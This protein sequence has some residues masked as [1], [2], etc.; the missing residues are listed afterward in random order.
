MMFFQHL[1][2]LRLHAGPFHSLRTMKW[3]A[4]NLL[5]K[6][7]RTPDDIDRA[8]SSLRYAIDEHNKNR[9]EDEFE[10]YVERLYTR[11][12]WELKYLEGADEE[13][14][15][16]RTEI[17]NLLENWP[18]WADD[19]PS[20]RHAEHFDDLESLQDLWV[21]NRP[22][23]FDRVLEFV[24][25]NEHES[26]A[27]LAL[28]KL[29]TAAEILHLPDHRAR[30]GSFSYPVSA[31]LPTH[32][33]AWAGNVLVETMEIICYAERNLAETHRAAWRAESESR[34]EQAQQEQEERDREAESEKA[35]VLANLR[36]AEDAEKRKA[37]KSLIRH[38]WD[39]WNNDRSRY[40]NQGEFARDMEEK[41]EVEIGRT[42]KLKLIYSAS[43]IEVKL[44]PQMRST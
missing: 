1:Y 12:G 37:A 39:L 23:S 17:R 31:P 24:D 16:T 32:A 18:D 36:W 22:Y 4:E 5:E 42:E 34:K 41:V 6:Q 38:Y 14:G 11:G 44:I 15:A 30:D 25:D 27:L 8:A 33:T 29:E 2:H 26:Y 43:T 7:G 13:I 19:K 3:R 21:S 9:A 20:F 35:R 10:Q 40:K 28:M